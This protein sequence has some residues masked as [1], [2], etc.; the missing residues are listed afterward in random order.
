MRKD[1]QFRR[2]GKKYKTFH[3]EWAVIIGPSQC[4]KSIL[5]DTILDQNQKI[6]FDA[7]NNIDILD[8]NDLPPY[9]PTQNC[10][11]GLKLFDTYQDKYMFPL[12]LKIIDTP[13]NIRNRTVHNEFIFQKPTILLLCFDYSRMLNRQLIID[14]TDFALT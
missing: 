4:G 8:Q 13:G 5:F 6:K 11:M 10:K 1:Q 12:S 14:W 7:E 3:S 2:I 9:T